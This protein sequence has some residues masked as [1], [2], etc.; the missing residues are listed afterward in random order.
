MRVESKIHLFGSQP[1]WPPYSS[2]QG[3]G[4]TVTWS[5]LARTL[6]QSS[7]GG[8]RVLSARRC[9][10]GCAR[11]TVTLFVT[12]ERVSHIYMFTH[13]ASCLE[14]TRV[15]GYPIASP[16]LPLCLSLPLSLSD[17]MCV[18]PS[19]C[20]PLALARTPSLTHSLS[21]SA[22]SLCLSQS[23]LSP[24]SLLSLTPSPKS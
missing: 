7:E 17:C 13:C 2:I 19:F 1:T 14:Q 23:S 21:A 10:V 8:G 15:E 22:P 20:L 24:L 18:Y 3:A 9:I 4:L 5:D 11:V 6:W 16:F 12:A